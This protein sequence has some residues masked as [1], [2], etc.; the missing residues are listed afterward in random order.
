MANIRE[1][2]KEAG[3]SVATVS[4]VLNGYPY[5]RE[6]KRNAVWEAVEKLNYTKNINAVHLAKGKN[7][8][9]RGHASLRESPVFR[10]HIGR[11]IKRGASSPVPPFAISNELR[12]GKGIR[13]IGNDTNETSRRAYY[14]FAYGGLGRNRGVQ[15]KWA[16]RVMRGCWR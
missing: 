12:C 8:D 9:Y 6:E 3:V 16:N 10:R 5:V 4:R 1:I 7:V 14:L 2:A 13:S 11:D 15:G